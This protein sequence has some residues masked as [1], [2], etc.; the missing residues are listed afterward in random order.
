M[1]ERKRSKFERE[2]NLER[3]TSLYLRGWR[4][5]DIATELNLSRE[6]VKYDLK[7]IQA[8]WRETTTINLDEAKQR[9]LARIDELE[10][11]YWV[12][13]ERSKGEKTKQRQETNGKDSTGKPKIVKATMEKDQMLGNPAFLTGVQ[14]CI[15]ERCKLL[16]IYAPTK[17]ELTGKDGKAI[18]FNEV[19][20]EQRIAR[21]ATILDKARDRRD[22]Q[23]N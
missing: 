1:A 2:Q 15:S 5:V 12:A 6:Q 9:E 13:W 3:T 7:D 21:I 20:D 22:R 23:A 18:E 10:R 8:R 17:A 16:G 19:D 4:Q 14:W 11:E